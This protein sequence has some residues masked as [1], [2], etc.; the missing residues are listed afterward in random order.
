MC[1]NQAFTKEQLR[2]TKVKSGDKICD[3]EAVHLLAVLADRV[4]ILVDF[5]FPFS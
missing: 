1:K 2:T 5:N 3:C 4:L